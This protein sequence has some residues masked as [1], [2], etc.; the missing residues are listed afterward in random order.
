MGSRRFRRAER[1]ERA[2]CWVILARASRVCGSFLVA[3]RQS[4]TFDRRSSIVERRTS[5]VERR[6]P[7]VER[8]NQS[9]CRVEFLRRKETPVRSFTA[10]CSKYVR[11]HHNIGAAIHE[12]AAVTERD[13][14][15]PR[16]RWHPSTSM[17]EMHIALARVVPGLRRCCKPYVAAA[18]T[19]RV[20]RVG[21][22]DGVENLSYRRLGRLAALWELVEREV[23][24]CSTPQ[25][26]SHVFL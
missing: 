13:I 7:N 3:T 23:D 18:L 20:H 4:I 21:R 1:H 17:H 14:R 26:F 19:D 15:F 12:R 2:R 22:D 16:H 10:T 11:K 25:Y 6:T 8:R 24:G 5:N 9:N